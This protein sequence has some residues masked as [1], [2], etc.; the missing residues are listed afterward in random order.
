MAL[1]IERPPC[2]T[3]PPTLPSSNTHRLSAATPRRAYLDDGRAPST[4]QPPTNVGSIHA[5][6]IVLILLADVV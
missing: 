5:T 2:G 4:S 3:Y 6:R 1:S